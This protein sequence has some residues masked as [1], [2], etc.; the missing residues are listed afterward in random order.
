MQAPHMTTATAAPAIHLQQSEQHLTQGLNRLKPGTMHPVERIEEQ[1]VLQREHM[2]QNLVRGVHGIHAPL[3]RNME[4]AI[5]GQIRRLP[6]LPT[7]HAGIE[8]AAGFDEEFEFADYMGGTGPNQRRIDV[9][10]AM[11]QRLGL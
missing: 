9:H 7:S 6:G 10:H 4:Y 8:T 2:R 1:S 11:E 3:R 5:L